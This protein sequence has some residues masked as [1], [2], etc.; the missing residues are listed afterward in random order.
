MQK[1][2]GMT[3]PRDLENSSEFTSINPENL[4]ELTWLF[5]Y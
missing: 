2:S 4:L 3:I 5:I 1:L